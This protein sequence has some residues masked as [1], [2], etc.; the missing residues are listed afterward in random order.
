MLKKILAL[1]RY[2]SVE[3]CCLAAIMGVAFW[4]RLR[5]LDWPRFHPD[6][7]PISHWIRRGSP[8]RLYPGGLFVIIRP[9]RF[10]WE[11]VAAWLYGLQNF[12]GHAE[13]LRQPVDFT[14]IGRTFNVLLGTVTVGIVYAMAKI[15]MRNGKLALVSAALMAFSQFHV[16]HSH[17]AQTD[18]PMV[19]MLALSLWTWCIHIVD[20]RR[21]WWIVTGLLCGFT[22]GTK[23]TLNMLIFPWLLYSVLVPLQ[24]EGTRKWKRIPLMLLGGLLLYAV[25]FFLANPN[26]TRWSR[27]MEGLA[28]ERSRVYAETALNMGMLAGDVA[29]RRLSHLYDLGRAALTLGWGWLILSFIGVPFMLTKSHRRF[30]IPMLLIP[31]LYGYYYIMVAPWVRNQE[32]L[33]FIPF[34]ALFA[35]LPILSIMQIRRYPIIRWTG[36]VI[37][38]V[39]IGVSAQRA[40][41]TSSIYEWLDT[42][43]LAER[44]LHRHEPEDLK[45]GKERYANVSPRGRS[46]YVDMA[47]KLGIT[48]AREMGLD[49]FLS[50]GTKA[51]RGMA[52]PV[53]KEL[54]PQFADIYQDFMTEATHLKSWSLLPQRSTR[55]TFNSFQIEM[56]GLDHD[57]DH[58]QWDNLLPQPVWI[59][60][61]P[62]ETYLP[63]GKQLGADVAVEV[64][65]WAR[66]IGI[67][68]RQGF[69]DPVFVIVYT[70]ER[71]AD[72]QVR[73]FGRRKK[74]RLGSYDY[75]VVAL[76]RSRWMPRLHHIETIRLRAQPQ[77]HIH[78]IPCYARIAFS[79][80]EVDR[81][82]SDITQSPQKRINI[83]EKWDAIDGILNAEAHEVSYLGVHAGYYNQFAR[84][85]LRNS[86]DFPDKEALR[87]AIPKRDRDPKDADDWYRREWETGVKRTGM[88]MSL[89]LRMAISMTDSDSRKSYGRIRIR[90]K[91][92]GSILAHIDNLDDYQS[93]RDL[94]VTLPRGFTGPLTFVI[95][96]TVRVAV[97]IDKPTLSWNFHDALA[98]WRDQSAIQQALYLSD[99]K[100]PGEAVAVL[101]KLDI[102]HNDPLYLSYQRAWFEAALVGQHADYNDIRKAFLLH[103]PKH[104]AAQMEEPSPEAD[105][106]AITFAPYLRLID[107]Q[108]MPE[109]ALAHVTFETMQDH[110]PPLH[111]YSKRRYR[112]G[113]R[114]IEH[115]KLVP[116]RPVAAGEQFTVSLPM[117]GTDATPSRR[118]IAVKSD[119]PWVAGHLSIDGQEDQVISV[120][121][122]MRKGIAE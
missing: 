2:V 46:V 105:R 95:E 60:E 90:E 7:Y 28:Y 40:F 13:Q 96:S 111:A 63:R 14:L 122:L 45:V 3:S 15:I 75:E 66:T 17:Y 54:Y 52:H 67:S 35:A 23:F 6:E 104:A 5:G 89:N 59:S 109:E 119:V 20:K 69:E 100:Q 31:L 56:Y 87:L 82:V 19:F 34:L 98:Y 93:A 58:H 97:E 78:Q 76:D 22:A 83:V 8:D 77:R 114:T 51:A 88:P 102:D 11:V 16:E 91:A 64:T 73:G 85:H 41:L 10:I 27:F 110:V 9:Y 101:Q 71:P 36:L 25:G 65:K 55:T 37:V 81:I 70:R 21:R 121:D 44:W 84:I 30:W 29:L 62:Y 103:A 49:L 48:S 79:R 94:K 113:W 118:G 80:E 18:V 74:V 47:G 1:K 53:T 42:R 4:L 43:L 86:V 33:N 92:T 39:A 117:R 120:K 68:N 24:Q 57:T 115:K 38:L 12:W 112:L 108:W 32:F 116:D 50:Q 106:A 99:Q 72:V 61:L 107:M 26:M